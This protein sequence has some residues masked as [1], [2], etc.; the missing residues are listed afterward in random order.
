MTRI[1][2]SNFRTR[3]WWANAAL[4]KR[5]ALVFCVA[6]WAVAV[7]I[8]FKILWSYA[9]TPGTPAEAPA[10]WPRS[11]RIKLSGDTPTLVM[12]AHPRCPCTK[13]TI[14][15]LNRIMSDC[16]GRLAATV[17]FIKPDG[18]KESWERSD[19]WSSAASIPGVTVMT[20]DDGNESSLFGSSTSGQV[21]LYD[22]N[23][24]LLFAGGITASRGHEGSNDGSSAIESL[25]DSGRSQ[26][27][28]TPVF[29]CPLDNPKSKCATEGN[30]E[31]QGS[32]DH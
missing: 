14:A 19:L 5:A 27:R 2:T 4:W 8:G 9:N 18:V 10:S 11:S 15:E 24:H 12:T 30:H 21:L 29:G 16:Q 26:Y 20:D 13:A 17:L 31:I 22:K 28:A 32:N 1:D 25:V 6:L 3:N 23:G 7:G